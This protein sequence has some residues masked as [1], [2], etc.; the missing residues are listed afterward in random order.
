MDQALLRSYSK[1][2]PYLISQHFLEKRG[3]VEI[4]AYGET[5]LSS[6]EKIAKECGLTKNDTVFEL[7]CGRGRTCFWLALF[8]EAKVIGIDFV[9]P[10]IQKSKEVAKQFH[11][12]NPTFKC[13]DFLNS[14]LHKATAIYLNGTCLKDSDITRLATKFAQLTPGTKIIT[15]SFKL[16]DYP[17][18]DRFELKKTFKGKFSWGSADVYLQILK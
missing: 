15:V 3:E 16:I 2:N 17:L 8:L 5:P 4:Y 1:D 13:E 11:L 7:G 18:G 12:K 6:M 10:F 9:P 14:D